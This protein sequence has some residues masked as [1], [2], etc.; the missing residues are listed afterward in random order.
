M[1]SMSSYL[2]ALEDAEGNPIESGCKTDLPIERIESEAASAPDPR[3]TIGD[4]TP[5]FDDA[6]LD[7]LISDWFARPAEV[8]AA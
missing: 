3:L 1:F 8:P 5:F 4:Y 2:W 6:A 7:R